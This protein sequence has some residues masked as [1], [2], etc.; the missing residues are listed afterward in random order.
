MIGPAPGPS[1]LRLAVWLVNVPKRSGVI[2]FLLSPTG[3][4]S[5][6]RIQ[7][8]LGMQDK[9][10]FADHLERLA[11]TPNLQRLLFGHGAPVTED[12]SGTLRRVAGQLRA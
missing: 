4:V 10:A 7:R 1:P 3:Q 8:W 12:A 11:D 6:P 2:G 9:R 5:T